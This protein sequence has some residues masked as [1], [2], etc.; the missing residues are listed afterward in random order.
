MKWPT[1]HTTQWKKARNVTV[2]MCSLS[3][4]QFFGIPWTVTH[5]VPL[6]CPFDFTGNNSGVGCH[7]LLQ[8]IYLIWGLN[9]IQIACFYLLLLRKEYMCDY[10]LNL[11]TAYLW[12]DIWIIGSFQVA[13]VLKIL[14]CLWHFHVWLLALTRF[15]DTLGQGSC[16]VLPYIPMC[17]G[18]YTYKT[19]SKRIYTWWS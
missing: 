17:T 3:R 7:F 5:P 16:S 2:G 15:H 1:K 12:K 19:L 13:V 10:M 14:L 18:T 11:Y 6:S 4:V 9:N 8:G